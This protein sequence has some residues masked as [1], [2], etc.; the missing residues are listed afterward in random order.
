MIASR[1]TIV[2]MSQSVHNE[3]TPLKER[4][5]RIHRKVI[6]CQKSHCFSKMSIATYRGVKYDTVKQAT[7]VCEVKSVREVYRGIEYTKSVKVCK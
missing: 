4:E 3:S 7:P 2:R 1:Q 6:R 5:T